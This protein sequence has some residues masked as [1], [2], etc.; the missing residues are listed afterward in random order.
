LVRI[1]IIV[2]LL[3]F[4]IGKTIRHFYFEQKIGRQYRAAYTIDET[5]ADILIFGSSRAFSNYIPDIFEENLKLSSYN[6]GSAGQFILYDYA[7]LKAVLK[8]YSPKLILLDLIPGELATEDRGHYYTYDRLSFLLPFYKEHEEMRPVLGLKGRFEKF[9]LASSIYPFN[10]KLIYIAASNAGYLKNSNTTI[11]GW[12]A[13]PGI[14]KGPLE[15]SSPSPRELD[16]TKIRVYRSF[17]RDCRRSG[18]KVVVVCSPTYTIFKA[19]D[20]STLVASKIAE[21]EN[22]RFID[23][24]NDS[25]FVKRSQ[26]FADIDH[27]NPNGAGIFTNS[28]IDSIGNSL[29]P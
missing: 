12:Q 5:N 20:N 9:K 26:L 13:V 4:A 15:V 10:S 17:L 19:K 18:V 25:F 6:T 1:L 21:E 14:W 22:M 3:D 16:S 28:I 7:V 23:F 2:F 24:T 11:K 27:L 29:Q 8:R